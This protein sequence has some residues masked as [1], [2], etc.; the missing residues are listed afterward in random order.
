MS[1]LNRIFYE[2]KSEF[3][4][5]VEWTDVED[6]HCDDDDQLTEQRAQKFWALPMCQQDLQRQDNQL[7]TLRE[8]AQCIRLMRSTDIESDI[9]F[10]IVNDN[11]A[12]IEN[13]APKDY[14]TYIYALSSLAILP[15]DLVQLA[16]Q[17]INE[18]VNVHLALNAVS[19]YFLSLTIPGAKS[20]GVFD[21]GVI[22]H[23]LRVF[24]LLE[25]YSNSSPLANNIWI[26]FLTICDDLKL[27]F[28]YV[29]FKDHLRP[30]DNIVR[31]LLT[32]LYMNFRHG[33]GNACAPQLHA[34]CFELLD[35]ITI[36]QNGDV[37]ETLM[38]IMSETFYMHIYPENTKGSGPKNGEHISDWFIKLLDKYP[39]IVSKVLENYIECVI[40]N[41]IKEWKVGDEKIAIGYAAKYDAALYAKCNKSCTD[42]LLQAIQADE[43]VGLQLRS[44][45][46]IERILQQQ[47]QVE[48]RIFRHDV[49]TK[50]REV[51]LIR[52]TIRCLDDKTFSV[53]RKASQVLA[54]SIRIGS[55]ITTRIL[56]EVINFVQY[57]DL[58]SRAKLNSRQAEI[59]LERPDNLHYVYSF[60]GFEELEAEVKRIPRLIYDRFLMSSNGLARCSGLALLERLIQINNRILYNTPFE[61]EISALATDTL[62]S[63]RKTTLETI[64]SLLQTYSNCSILVDVYCRIWSCMLNDDDA[65]LQK[66][67]LHSFNRNVLLNIKPLEYSS[68]SKHLL[69]WHI[70]TTLLATQPR[71]Y[72][73]QR[74]NLLL[75]NENLVTPTLVNTII[76][77]LN[78][79][80]A[81]EAWTLLLLI[82]SRITNNLDS[83]IPTFD[84]LSSYNMKSNQVL[85][86]QLI[87]Y[88]LSNFSKASLNQLFKSLL[89]LMST[90]SIWLEVISP[91]MLLL[92]HIDQLSH[93]QAPQNSASVE[94]WQTQLLEDVTAATKE[95]IENFETDHIRMTSLL[96]TYSELIVMIP[97]EA[98]EKIV[99]FVLG[100]VKLCMSLNESSFDTDNER[101]MN[102]MV[103][104]AGRLS[105]R[106]NDLAYK[107]AKMYGQILSKN[108]RPQLINSTLI[109]LNDLGKK[110]P[111]ILES[112]MKCILVKLSS[113][114][115]TTR[116]RTYRCVKDVIL[117]G[118]IKL[119][120][121][122]LVSLLAGLVDDS[123]E[124]AREADAFFIRYKK[125]YDKSLF[126]HCLKEIPFDLND[127]AF[128]AGSVRMEAGFKSP[129]KGPNK[130]KLR[131]L[132][133]NH[134]LAAL[135]ENTL[136]L[137]FGQL[138]L[139]AEK[140]KD[141]SFIE[142]PNA[143]EVVI[144]LLFI[145]R[146]ICFCTKSKWQQ[147]AG[148]AEGEEDD[149]PQEEELP[150]S[151]ITS[152][153][154]SPA[155][156]NAAGR[157]RG[158]GLRK[159][160]MAEE[161]LKQLERCLRYVEEIHR[162][163]KKY[164]SSDLH[165]EFKSFCRAMTMR[166]PNLT[167]FA[168][169]VHFWLKYKIKSGPRCKRR[170]LNEE[171]DD[172]NDSDSTESNSDTD[173]DLPL[174][175]HK[176]VSSAADTAKDK[177]SYDV[178]ATELI[179]QP[180][181]W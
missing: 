86:L 2:L 130:R 64:D 28:R 177:S 8:L 104:I 95:C 148:Q 47:T 5:N 109:C 67:A 15:H 172:A 38:H 125:L 101:M 92:H 36:A 163:L 154:Q 37:Y 21:E 14:L 90:G 127:Q 4:Q 13:I 76:S 63:V 116:V 96:A 144:D 20:Y 44:L 112:N 176:N 133:Y 103:V 68:E 70:V 74:F 49:S 89:S 43:A 69:P 140:T 178:L 117:A 34:K 166:F 10:D 1:D 150:P 157:G 54:L 175:R 72:L 152:A 161:P 9:R 55:P 124:V 146:R 100:Y 62:S 24:R 162:N 16:P 22:E 56:N 26:L 115:A 122:I 85:A 181:D 48:W 118:N 147:G 131:R 159:R 136:L 160:E 107:V 99:D 141:A 174:E 32:I 83:I 143:L 30:R 111:S 77:H 23:C 114:Y 29:H 170:R 66:L 45:E 151:A 128:L 180:L 126:H 119:K 6:W 171:G 156:D 138:K 78:T 40:T 53:R 57:D 46:L 94:N 42:L 51:A 137:Y 80:M 87:I 139:L 79:P 19:T 41:P 149:I 179:F 81:T 165:R 59:S 33:Y 73:Q 97:N 121:A 27:V 158:R 98:D 3:A 168:Q 7:Q 135:D 167:D 35:E 75:Q 91:A 164:M 25:S 12:K 82:S 17:T 31:C 84:R 18:N 110:Y 93:S 142:L 65:Q 129:L 50:P 52:E 155:S 123:I 71:D 132:L 145:M 88:C 108:D 173:S 11:W 58:E 169:P 134:I 153:E 113:K 60:E 102:W 105:L 106:D 39:D 120:G 61:R